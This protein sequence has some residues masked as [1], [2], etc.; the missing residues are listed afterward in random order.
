[1]QSEKQKNAT[2]LKQKSYC[3][4]SSCIIRTTGERQCTYNYIVVS[5][6]VFYAFSTEAVHAYL[7]I[8]TFFFS[9]A[10]IPILENNLGVQEGKQG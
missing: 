2:L 8:I 5:C 4:S 6:I 7:Y 1:M 3:L 10:P 9:S